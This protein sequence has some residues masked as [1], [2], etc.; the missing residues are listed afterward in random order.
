M[1]RRKLYEDIKDKESENKTTIKY[2]YLLQLQ[3][4]DYDVYD[5]Q[6]MLRYLSNE[7]K[8]SMKEVLLIGLKDLYFNEISNEEK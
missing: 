1:V 2:S 3:K 6:K 5:F 4:E 7:W 8:C